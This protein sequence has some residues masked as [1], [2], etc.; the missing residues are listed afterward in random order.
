VN[1][2]K[3]L[4]MLGEQLTKYFGDTKEV[5][6]FSQDCKK[7]GMDLTSDGMAIQ[8]SKKPEWFSVLLTYYELG[9]L[10]KIAKSIEE[11]KKKK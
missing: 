1:N 8:I 7:I 11:L 6:E 9:L 2:E 5:K 4:E 3:A 10:S